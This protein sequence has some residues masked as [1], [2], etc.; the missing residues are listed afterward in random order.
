MAQNPF[1][2]RQIVYNS[3]DNQ[4]FEK[5]LRPIDAEAENNIFYEA[6]IYYLFFNTYILWEKLV[7]KWFVE[8]QCFFE[9]EFQAFW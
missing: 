7:S 8:K 6:K 5:I 9:V 2:N 3:T 4:N 1:K